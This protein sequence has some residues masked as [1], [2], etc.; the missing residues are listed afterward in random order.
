VTG[1]TGDIGSPG[2]TGNL[3]AVGAIG[4]TGPMGPT[5]PSCVCQVLQKNGAGKQHPDSEIP[6]QLPFVLMSS[7]DGRFEPSVKAER[8]EFIE[9]P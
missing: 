8:S 7:P 3:G 6:L 5:G 1:N 9:E 2:A 4:V